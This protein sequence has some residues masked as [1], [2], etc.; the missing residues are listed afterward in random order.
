[1]ENFIK[2]FG[3]EPRKS[4]HTLVEYRGFSDPDRQIATA[5]RLLARH[6]IENY[7]IERQP[8]VRGFTIHLK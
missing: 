6:K 8:L 4:N 3:F 2:S 1:M 5:E 7:R